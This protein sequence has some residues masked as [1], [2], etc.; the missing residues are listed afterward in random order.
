MMKTLTRTILCTAGLLA[1][2]AG[3]AWAADITATAGVSVQSDYRFRGISQNDQQPSP[4]A[5]LNLFGPDGWYAGTW[6]AKI[7][8]G[9]KRPSGGANNPSIETDFYLGKHTALFDSATDLSVEA[10]Y[11]AYPDYNVGGG[12]KASFVEAIT[13]LSH[14]FGNTTATLIWAISPEYSL[15]GGTS[16]FLASNLSYVVNDWISIS[17]NVGHQWVQNTTN[18]YT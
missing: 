15:G 1:L 4:E 13:Q 11:Y 5:T 14:N 9:V 2:S 12:P 6:D 18:D 16:N 17:G 8:W 3:S 10:H 7:D